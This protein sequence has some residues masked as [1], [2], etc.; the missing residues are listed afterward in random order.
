MKRVFIALGLIGLFSAFYLLF[1]DGSYEIKNYPSAGTEVVV[2]GDSLVVGVGST[3]GGDFVSVLSGLIDTPIV[4]LG[5]SGDTTASALTRLDEV[6]E[7]K[8]KVVLLLLGG[9]DYLRKVPIEETFS[10]LEI[11]IEAVHETGAVVV[12]L[13]VRGGVLSDNY[14]S[15]YKALAKKHQTAYVQDVL[16]GVLGTSGLMYDNI[17]PNTAG[18]KIIA[19]KIYPVLSELLE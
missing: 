8:P 3:D 2:F 11:M 12:L 19:N 17:H 13:G 7:I 18:Y 9:N 10:N 6:L 16:D 14:K 1:S 4:N 5:K 15:E